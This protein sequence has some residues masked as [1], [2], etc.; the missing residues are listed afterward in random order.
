MT[1]LEQHYEE[2]C[3]RQGLRHW[4][5]DPYDAFE[6]GAELASA[7]RTH[8][9]NPPSVDRTVP[10]WTWE[11]GYRNPCR[12][13]VVRDREA[14]GL[15][16]RSDDPW[17]VWRGGHLLLAKVTHAQAIAAAQRIAQ[18]DAACPDPDYLDAA[19]NIRGGSR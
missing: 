16:Q 17:Q 11:Y 8:R 2:W 18:H 15:I 14:L 1:A 4:E 12:V 7:D 9:P 10:L 5:A 6:A 3:E 13:A 19:D